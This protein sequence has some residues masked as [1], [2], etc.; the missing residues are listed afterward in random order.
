ME[1]TQSKDGNTLQEVRVSAYGIVAM[2]GFLNWL[3]AMAKDGE[4]PRLRALDIMSV[5]WPNVPLRAAVQLLVGKV[6]FQ[7]TDAIVQL[8]S[9]DTASL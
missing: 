5:T 9:S 2:P 8:G 4:G 7:G 6:E 3:R 1:D